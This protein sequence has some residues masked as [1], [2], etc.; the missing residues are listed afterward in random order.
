MYKLYEQR[1]N[2][3]EQEGL[4][5][6]LRGGYKGLE[7]E[8][9]RVN[10]NGYIS[11]ADHPRALGAALTHPYITTDYS[12]ALLEFVTPPYADALEAQQFLGQI[13]QYVFENIEHDE[14]LW[15]TS[16]PCAVRGDDSV[17]I[18][19]YGDTNQARFKEIYRVGLGNRYGRIMQTIA[20]VH[21][22]Y[23]VPRRFWPMFQFIEEN[24]DR[25]QDFRSAGY[26]GLVRNAL[27]YDWLLFYLFGSS[28]AICQTFLG[29]QPQGLDWY[30]D[31][32]TLYKPYATTL[33]MSKIGYKNKLPPTF[34]ISVDSL[35]DYVTGLTYA[36]ETPH[37]AYRDIGVL[38]DG[39]YRQLNNHILQIENEFYSAIRPKQSPHG[40]ERPGLALQRRGIAY[41]EL[42]AI[43]I[44]PFSPTGVNVDQL[45]FLEAFLLF[46]LLQES[47]RLNNA[48]R[49]MIDLNETAVALNGR[50]PELILQ[51]EDGKRPMLE[52][53]AELLTQIEPVCRILDDGAAEG[54]YARALAA[55]QAKLSDA[56]LLPSA[57]ILAEMREHGETFHKF[58]RR[59]SEKHE[60]SFRS[61]PL[62]GERRQFFQ[63]L[64]TES[65]E[66]LE[67]LE[68]RPQ[69]PFEEYRR[70]Y[71]E[72]K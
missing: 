30:D 11:Q 26:M 48:E 63:H 46:C 12:E 55:Q 13:H 29:G 39:E 66:R 68:A 45:H 37:A 16:M 56:A 2:R 50:D 23:S 8:S 43:D 5:R 38:V 35:A 49:R 62:K 53:A 9:L 33:R 67:K 69:S 20:G 70:A 18:A 14:M 25:P 19:S 42:R 59:W 60:R 1:L 61:E 40:G 47:P 4:T 71:F 64:T 65:L 6:F 34:M 57:R 58:A 36:I 24:N 17:R 7:K 22:N 52:W 21:Y 31:R 3:L 15:A 27:R 44:D 54:P 72:Q 10:Q 41:V 32:H 28:P 51:T